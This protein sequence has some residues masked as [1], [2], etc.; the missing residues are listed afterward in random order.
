M[1][2]EVLHRAYIGPSIEVLHRSYIG[3]S[4]EVLHRSYI[5][6][7]NIDTGISGHIYQGLYAVVS[8]AA[9]LIYVCMYI[10]ISINIYMYV[11]IRGTT[12]VFLR[13]RP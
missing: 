4:I 8:K 13:Q 6:P 2:I 3:P 12:Q 5:G 11:C 10:Y 9:S 7:S 1:Y